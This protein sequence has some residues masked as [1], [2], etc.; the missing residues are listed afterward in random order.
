MIFR[1]N[2]LTNNTSMYTNG[3]HTGLITTIIK[4][5]QSSH[6]CFLDYTFT[7]ILGLCNEMCNNC[8]F[9]V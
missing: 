6:V 8:N 7:V 2:E 9:T 1:V 3:Q 5:Y 4:Y